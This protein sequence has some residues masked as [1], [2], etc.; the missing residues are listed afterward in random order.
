MSNIEYAGPTEFVHLHCHTVYSTLDGVQTPEQLFDVCA[1]RNWPAIAI[2]EHGNLASVPDAYFAAKKKGIKYIP[3]CEIYFND[4]EPI[5]RERMGNGEKM[6]AIKQSNPDLYTRIMR[7]R[8]LTIL[9]KNMTGFYNL[10]KMTT[11]A[12]EFGFY[13]RPRIWFDKLLEYSEGLI[14]L[15]GCLNGPVSYE[16]RNNILRSENEKGALDYAL[17]FKEAFGD[18][19]FIEV[20]MPCL[21][22]GEADDKKAFWTLNKIASKYGIRPVLT[23]DAHY[24]S[25]EDFEVQKL[26]MAIGQGLT[27]DD[28]EL[29]HVNSD[30]QFLKT[31]SQL[32]ETFKSHGYDKHTN[33]SRFEEMCDNTLY[34]AEQCETFDPDLEPKIPTAEADPG[35]LKR[36]VLKELMRRGLHNQ[37]EKYMVD[38]REVTYLEQV[39]IELNRFIEKGFASYFLITQDLVRF[40]LASG[41][42]IGPRGCTVPSALI[43]ITNDER[44]KIEDIQIGDKIIDGFGVSQIVENKFIYDISEDLLVFDLGDRIIEVTNDHKLYIIRDSIVMLLRAAEVKDTDEII[45]NLKDLTANHEDN[46][47]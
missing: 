21:P 5:R 22:D 19:Y 35:K 38:N 11:E 6:G 2:T 14:V 28:P 26:M 20:Q 39:K 27:I 37:T 36:F 15:S 42:P 18:N 16:A 1:D 7:N 46:K 9:A 47:S 25:R 17:K 13:S 32:Y 31:R 40:S 29:F 10:V 23:N 43:E 8:H 4:Y 12:W 44:K 33:D 34:A 24:L 30:E 3:G 41:W 45:G